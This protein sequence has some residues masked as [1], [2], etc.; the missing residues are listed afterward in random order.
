MTQQ[1]TLP[2]RA[3]HSGAEEDLI[4]ALIDVGMARAGKR[5]LRPSQVEAL[6][7]PRSR[8]CQAIDM[9]PMLRL[10][11]FPTSVF[12]CA[13]PPPDPVARRRRWWHFR[14]TPV[15][16]TSSGTGALTVKRAWSALPCSGFLRRN[17]RA[18]WGQRSPRRRSNE[19]LRAWDS[20]RAL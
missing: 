6:G 7:L 17:S 5:Q 4:A 8:A 14:F 13:R 2:D 18:N 10:T 19:E 16:G 3:F 11:S 20:E 15:R 9:L 1:L 12:A